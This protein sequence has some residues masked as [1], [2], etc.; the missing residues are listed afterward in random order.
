MVITLQRLLSLCRVLVVR[1]SNQ[2]TVD[3]FPVLGSCLPPFFVQRT[4]KPVCVDKL[5]RLEQ[6]R[7]NRGWIN[8]MNTRDKHD[9]SQHCKQKLLDPYHDI[10]LFIISTEMPCFEQQHERTRSRHNL[11]FL[12]P[13]PLPLQSLHQ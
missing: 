10:P 11:L 12:Q 3:N 9:D 4:V 13:E 8:S 1:S 7:I 5:T 6:M 2:Q